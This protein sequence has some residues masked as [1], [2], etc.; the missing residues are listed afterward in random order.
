MYMLPEVS[1]GSMCR[2]MS[3]S[4]LLD[5][6]ARI[7]HRAWL[8]GLGY[9]T[10]HD[11]VTLG[12]MHSEYPDIRYQVIVILVAHRL[13]CFELS[14]FSGWGGGYLFFK[15]NVEIY[16]EKLKSRNKWDRNCFTL[17]SLKT[18]EMFC[19]A[20]CTMTSSLLHRSSVSSVVFSS[21]QLT[22]S[23]LV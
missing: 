3:V 16:F 22:V 23:I 21:C 1:D 19:W 12:V 5:P 7:P 2:S 15:L 14:I 9:L 6:R 10:V 11:S 4:G 17:N 13:T 18:H 20:F 8:P